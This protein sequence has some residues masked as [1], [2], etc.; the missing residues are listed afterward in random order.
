[1][2]IREGET[3]VRRP[4]VPQSHIPRLIIC[5][6]LNGSYCRPRLK[7]EVYIHIW[8]VLSL[9]LKVHIALAFS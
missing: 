7:N 9:T 5:V 6:A 1:M 4:A 2:D 8:L 3:S